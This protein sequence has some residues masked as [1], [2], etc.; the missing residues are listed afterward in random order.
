M[1]SRGLRLIMERKAM[2]ILVCCMGMLRVTSGKECRTSSTVQASAKSVAEN[3]KDGGHIWQHVRGLSSRPKG[4]Q[5][6]ETQLQKTLFASETDYKN[7]WAAFLSLDLRNPQECKGKQ[8]GQTVDCVLAKDIGVRTAYKCTAVEKNTN[9]CTT[10]NTTSPVYVEFWYAQK[11]GKWVLNTAYPS[12]A[13]TPTASCPK[14]QTKEAD[15]IDKIQMEKLFQILQL[16]K[17]LKS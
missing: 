2:I 8:H 11:G 5:K 10:E 13:N 17:L 9:L 7:A 6:S 15:V 12:G 1:C 4:A 14:L 16:L 3:S